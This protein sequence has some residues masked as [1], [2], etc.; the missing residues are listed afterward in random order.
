MTS[1]RTSRKEELIDCKKSLAPYIKENNCAPIMIRLAWHDSGTYD[2]V[3]LL[4]LL[5]AYSSLDCAAG[6]CFLSSPFR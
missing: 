2:K 4:L 5:R 3:S 6:F 1:A